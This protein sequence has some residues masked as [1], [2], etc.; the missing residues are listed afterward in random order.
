MQTRVTQGSVFSKYLLGWAV[1]IK[2]QRP[3]V[4]GTFG[5]LARGGQKKAGL[6][7]Q[8]RQTVADL[9]IWKA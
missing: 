6:K 3:E 8:H 9:K 5:E 2:A 4:N 7:L 1:P